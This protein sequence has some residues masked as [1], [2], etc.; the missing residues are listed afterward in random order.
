MMQASGGVYDRIQNCDSEGRMG[1]VLFNSAL[2][3]TASDTRD[4]FASKPFSSSMATPPPMLSR[5]R[6]GC[7]DG[8]WTSL[9]FQGII[10]GKN[11]SFYSAILLQSK[12]GSTGLGSTSCVSH[13]GFG[14]ASSVSH[15]VVALANTLKMK[16]VEWARAFTLVCRVSF[17]NS[18][19][20]EPCRSVAEKLDASPTV[21]YKTNR[22]L[23]SQHSFCQMQHLAREAL[24]PKS[25]HPQNLVGPSDATRA[26]I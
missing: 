9:S 18:F 6:G 8:L 24:A 12:K 7:Y 5:N 19:R 4:P 2:L 25:F 3:T 15:F 11:V 14:S 13:F 23:K 26:P 20:G 17:E 22:M 10:C 16:E 21:P 1:G